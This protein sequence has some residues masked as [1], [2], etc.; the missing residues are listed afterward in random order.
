M[1]FWDIS[2]WVVLWPGSFGDGMF[3]DGSFCDLG[4]LVMGPLV[5]G[6]C[7]MGHLV[8]SR[9]VMGLF[10]CELQLL[11]RWQG[12]WLYSTTF[13]EIV[14]LLRS[15]SFVWDG[16]LLRCT[17]ISRN[18][19]FSQVMRNRSRSHIKM[20]KFVSLYSFYLFAPPP[21]AMVQIRTWT[22][23]KHNMSTSHY[24]YIAGVD[25]LTMTIVPQPNT[26]KNSF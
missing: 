25:F 2:W 10:V 7:V 24:A 12:Y 15:F 3:C 6:H 20:Y 22:Y 8:M 11:Y 19:S 13:L 21:E 18:L 23:S 26:F 16:I 14:R 17:G 5:M 9:F 4:C 1:L